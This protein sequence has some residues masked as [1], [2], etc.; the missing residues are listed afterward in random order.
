MQSVS[1]SV[2]I[3]G[4]TIGF[5]AQIA[6]DGWFDLTLPIRSGPHWKA[7]EHRLAESVSPKVIDWL[8]DWERSGGLFVRSGQ[9]V[10]A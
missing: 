3:D 1:G 4:Q 7:A 2:T 10:A 5:N 8:T 6:R 9:V